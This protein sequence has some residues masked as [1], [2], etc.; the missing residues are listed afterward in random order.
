M[1][2]PDACLTKLVSSVERAVE[3]LWLENATHIRT[4]APEFELSASGEDEGELRCDADAGRHDNAAST[5]AGCTGP[6]M[7]IADYTYVCIAAI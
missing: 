1:Q 4:R 7:H 6:G 3:A 2:D 5:P